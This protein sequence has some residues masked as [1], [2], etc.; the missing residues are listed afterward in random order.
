LVAGEKKPWRGKSGGVRKKRGR[1]GFQGK[2]VKGAVGENVAFQSREEKN[3]GEQGRQ[4]QPRGRGG[5][6]TK[7]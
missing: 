3:W 4:A 6:G 5:P 1:Q 2:K 7:T